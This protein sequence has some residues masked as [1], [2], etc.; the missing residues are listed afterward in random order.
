M[1]WRERGKYHYISSREVKDRLAG[2]ALYCPDLGGGVHHFLHP[3]G[4]VKRS[5]SF[6]GII[7]CR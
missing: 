7:V 3:G 6:I 5:D 4:E 2:N 1:R